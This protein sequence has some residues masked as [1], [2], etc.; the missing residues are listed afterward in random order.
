MDLARAFAILAD[1]RADI[2]LLMVGPDEES[3]T[4]AIRNVCS[5]HLARLHFCAYANA[6]EDFMTASDILCL[7]SYREGFGTVIIEAAAVG[8]PTVASRIYG[9]VDAVV[10]GKTGLL[11][12]PAD[13]DGLAGQ[14]ER[15]M[16]SPE[17]RR[18]LGA[19]A[20]ARAVRDF[21]QS[22][23]TSAVLDVYSRLLDV[24][25]RKQTVTSTGAAQMAEGSF[26]AETQGVGK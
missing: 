4:G 23:M 16:S 12:E 26:R 9:V 19:E 13:L 15:L 25:P 6:P 17:L 7:P 20:R 5:R 18:S 3:L 8:L 24:A 14:L 10:D 1:R 21:S 2:R 22:T 11:H